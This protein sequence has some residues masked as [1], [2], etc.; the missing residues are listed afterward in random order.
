ME[1]RRR[2]RRI[3]ERLPV[4]GNA[5]VDEYGL[6]ISHQNLVDHPGPSLAFVGHVRECKAICEEPIQTYKSPGTFPLLVG[7]APYFS[8]PL[9]S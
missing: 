3:W 6:F 5:Q 9:R 8:A 7:A 1:S 4:G 2:W